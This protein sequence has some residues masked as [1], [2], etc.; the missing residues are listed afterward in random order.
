MQL[1]STQD[2]LPPIDGGAMSRH[3]TPE[4]AA[5]AEFYRALNARDLELMAQS[6]WTTD[7]ASMANPLGGVVRGWDK[8]SAIYARMFRNMRLEIAL[9][10]Y[11][12]HIIGSVFYAIGRERGYVETAE[13]RIELDV[14]T[15]RVFRLEVSRWRQAHHH[16]SIDDPELLQMYQRALGLSLEAETRAA[17]SH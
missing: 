1:T 17:V 12:I 9:C 4:I 7:E 14:R 6:W 15:T 13:Q 10:D 16:G 8:I 5:L 11:T 3:S 2:A